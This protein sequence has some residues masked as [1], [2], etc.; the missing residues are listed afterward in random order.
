M[1]AGAAGRF[2]RDAAHVVWGRALD[3]PAKASSTPSL[4]NPFTLSVKRL[5]LVVTVSSCMTISF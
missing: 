1:A 2:K 4:H 3:V 5:Q